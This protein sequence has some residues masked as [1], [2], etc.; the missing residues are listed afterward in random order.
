MYEHYEPSERVFVDREEYLDW[1]ARALERCKEQSVVLHLRGIGGIGKS[2]LLNHWKSTVDDTI[3]LDCE[4]HA[5]FYDRLNVVAKG[6]VNLGV[7]LRRFDVLWQIRLRFVEGLEPVREEGREWAKEVVMAIPFIGS[8]AS[9]GS[10]IGAVGA[11]V[12][13]KL[14]K[15]IEKHLISQERFLAEVQKLYSF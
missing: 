6:A 10:A 15:P 8:L 3:Y 5:E 1:M 4:R 14:K 2:S 12:G 11:K 7:N 9:I 13:P